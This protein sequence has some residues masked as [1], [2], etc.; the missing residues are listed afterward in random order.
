[1]VISVAADGTPAIKLLDETGKVT[2][3][4]TPGDKR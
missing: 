1:V 2:G 3:Q 4:L